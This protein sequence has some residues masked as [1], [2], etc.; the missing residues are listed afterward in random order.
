MKN[1]FPLTQEK[2]SLK[3]GGGSY[4][5]NLKNILFQKNFAFKFKSLLKYSK[6]TRMQQ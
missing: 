6:R 2:L 4:G 1:R 5:P 3:R